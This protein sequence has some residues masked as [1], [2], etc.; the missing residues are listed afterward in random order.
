MCGCQRLVGCVGVE[1]WMGI[2]GTSNSNLMLFFI[3][4]IIC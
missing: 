2:V 4:L 1:G 3:N